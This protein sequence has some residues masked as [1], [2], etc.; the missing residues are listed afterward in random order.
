MKVRN[1]MTEKKTNVRRLGLV[2]LVIFLFSYVLNF[3][4]ESFHSALLYTCCNFAPL[5]YVRV[6]SYASMMDGLLIIGMYLTISVLWG[7][8][9]WIKKMNKKQLSAFIIVGLFVTT[10]IEYKAVYIFNQWSYSS[11]MPT[12][13]GIG[14]SPLV[15][16]S[17]TGILVLW[18]TRR[19]LY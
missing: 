14:L 19:L 6:M 17:A 9:L 2:F 10:I 13:F 5:K 18:L 12:I 15:Q 4:W 11:L 1:K 7:D 8:L 3:V 16:L